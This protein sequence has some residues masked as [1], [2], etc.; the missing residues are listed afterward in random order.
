MPIDAR[1]A[2]FVIGSDVLGPMGQEL[3]PFAR[4]EEARGFMQDHHG[5]T[6]LKFDDI[7][8]VTLKEFN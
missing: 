2:W 1:S 5:R 7:T 3:I 4:E 8:P 6:V